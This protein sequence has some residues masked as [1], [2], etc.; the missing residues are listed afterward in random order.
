VVRPTS[1]KA[2][3]AHEFER[4]TGR[5]ALVIEGNAASC[6]TRAAG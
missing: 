6:A 2:Q 1:L 3:W 4:F 5:R